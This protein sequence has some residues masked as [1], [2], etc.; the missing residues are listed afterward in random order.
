MSS[1]IPAEP[2]RYY[3]ND[4]FHYSGHWCLIIPAP[5]ILAAVDSLWLSFAEPTFAAGIEGDMMDG[6]GFDRDNTR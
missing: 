1:A 4:N 5:N 6:C 2:D 3:V